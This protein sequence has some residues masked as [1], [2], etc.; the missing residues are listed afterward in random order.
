MSRTTLESGY[1]TYQTPLGALPSVTT[2]LSATDSDKSK[3]ALGEWKK[4][5][6]ESD[7]ASRGTSIHKWVELTLKK[8]SPEYPEYQGESLQHWCDPLRLPLMQFSR[9]IWIE[10]PVAGHNHTIGEDGHARVWSSQ[11]YA[12][13]PDLIGERF[14]SLCLADLKSSTSWY[15]RVQPRWDTR[16]SDPDFWLKYKGYNYKFMRVSM[17][18]VAYADAVEETL[19]LKPTQLMVL[20]SNPGVTVPAGISHEGYQAI[21]L[22]DKEIQK[23]RK[24]WQTRLAKFKAMRESA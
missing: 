8:E 14:N 23:A 5:N 3:Q 16:E 21:T 11:G 20:V 17:Q 24:E 1:R 15:C 7:A 10:G 13:C 19:G 2:I 18:L 9:M 22:S 4:R 6:P 12:G